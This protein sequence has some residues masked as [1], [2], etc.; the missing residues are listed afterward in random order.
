M[1]QELA[2]QQGLDELLEATTRH[3]AEVFGGHVALFL[4][5]PDSQLVRRAG[6]LGPGP[7]DANELGVVRWVHEHGQLAGHGSATL[8]GARALYL[9]LTAA[10]EPLVG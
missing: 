7:D 4:P 3:V 8:P 6:E 1:T 10:R 2:S 5:S 9:P